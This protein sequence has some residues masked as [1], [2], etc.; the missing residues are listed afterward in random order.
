MKKKLFIIFFIFLIIINIYNSCFASL[1]FTY[2][3][4][5]FSLPDL[6][7]D[8]QYYTILI[9]SNVTYLFSI[10]DLSTVYYN[11]AGNGNFFCSGIRYRLS[12]SSWS[13]QGSGSWGASS[14]YVIRSNFDIKYINSDEIY[15]KDTVNIDNPSGSNYGIDTLY[16]GDI[17]EEF[18]YAQFNSDYVTLYNKS[19]AS[20]EEL[21]YYRIYFIDNFFTYDSGFSRFDNTVNFQKINVSNKIYYRR[22]F[23]NILLTTFIIIIFF[24]WVT[25]LFTTIIYKGGI[26]RGL[27]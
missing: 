10:T 18:C 14:P 6:P 4:Q 26:L 24:L 11:P 27:F 7:T 1:D 13:N 3:E 23:P 9:S 20:N 25:N 19:S 17:P 15:F 16:I 2:N 8:I 5:E 22:D 21:Q 12:G